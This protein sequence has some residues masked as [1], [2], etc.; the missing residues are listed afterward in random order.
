MEW[1]DRFIDYHTFQSMFTVLKFRGIC[2]PCFF[3]AGV[4]LDPGFSGFDSCQ[5]PG[6][7]VCGRRNQRCGVC[8]IPVRGIA[9]LS[10]LDRT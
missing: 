8:I 1:S 4:S 6:M 5:E 9:R 7:L 3:E 10:K 2:P